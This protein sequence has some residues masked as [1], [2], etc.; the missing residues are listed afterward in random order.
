[1]GKRWGGE[2]QS[3][4]AFRWREEV[5]R[6]RGGSVR[7]LGVVRMAVTMLVVCSRRRVNA[8]RADCVIIALN[9]RAMPSRAPTCPNQTVEGCREVRTFKAMVQ[10]DAPL[11]FS[12]SRC[13][14]RLVDTSLRLSTGGGFAL[15]M[16]AAYSYTFG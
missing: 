2:G 10:F 14:R 11:C 4:D 16:K 1:M 3:C 15:A 8:C 7:V 12:S 13:D 5:F 6:R 9:V